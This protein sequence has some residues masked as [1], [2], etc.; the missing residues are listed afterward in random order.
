MEERLHSNSSLSLQ[1]L[2]FYPFI[3]CAETPF[4]QSTWWLWG[5]T[6]VSYRE[7]Q[8]CESPFEATPRR[9][10]CEAHSRCQQ[11]SPRA[12]QRR[13]SSAGDGAWR[14]P[15]RGTEAVLGQHLPCVCTLSP[16]QPPGDQVRYAQDNGRC[17]PE[18][19]G[20]QLGQFP[21][22]IPLAATGAVGKASGTK[23]GNGLLS[24]TICHI[25]F[26]AR[27]LGSLSIDK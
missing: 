22:G 17:W 13:L 20:S 10:L 4:P 18:P 9:C 23:G 2:C 6:Y 26:V 16:S 11:Q 21:A 7:A 5:P 15:S 25:L 27:K 12:R 14:A 24:R 8:S 3:S 19:H 1:A